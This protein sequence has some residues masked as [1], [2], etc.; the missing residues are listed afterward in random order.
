MLSILILLWNAVMTAYVMTWC[1]WLLP[2]SLQKIKN[3]CSI[4]IEWGSKLWFLFCGFL[5]EGN[6]AMK[7][8]GRPSWDLRAIE[9]D[10]TDS[11]G[12][13]QVSSSTLGGPEGVT[14]VPRNPEKWAVFSAYTA[15][16]SVIQPWAMSL[17]DAELE[18]HFKKYM[19]GR[20][21]VQANRFKL[22]TAEVL[23]GT[24][25]QQNF[26]NAISQFFVPDTRLS[27]IPRFPCF[28]LVFSTRSI[29]GIR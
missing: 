9:A 1:L 27:D 11:D 19:V 7:D 23:D 8:G 14:L 29:V 10:G 5:K 6:L 24:V 20:G 3:N 28:V 25:S 22:T 2:V 26:E 17:T 15:A 21:L 12:V 16:L 4:C 18:Q 13:F